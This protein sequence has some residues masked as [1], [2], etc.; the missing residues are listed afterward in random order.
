ME[1]ASSLPVE[2][3]KARGLA[4]AVSQL[5]NELE[6]ARDAIWR[7]EADLAAGVPVT[8]TGRD[9]EHLVLRLEAVLKGGAQA[10]GC[11]AAAVY[12][13]DEATTELKLRVGWGLPRHRLLALP[14][15]LRGAIADLEALVGHAVVLEDTERLPQ[16]RVPE[17][18]DA[19]VCVPICSPTE[20]LGTLWMFCDHPR[21]FSPDQTNLIEIIAGRIAAELQ[22]E[23][24]LRECVQTKRLDRQLLRAMEWQNDRLPSIQPL[25]GNWELAGWVG[26]NELLRAGFYDWCVPS[27]GSLAV[28]LGSAEG[29]ML[30][31]AMTAAA[32]HGALR[33]H[34]VHRHDAAQMLN[35][36]NET[37]WTGSA[38][39]QFA[40]LFYAL[41]QPQTGELEYASAGGLCGMRLTAAGAQCIDLAN[42]SLGAQPADIYTLSRCELQHGDALL[43]FS[44][45]ASQLADAAPSPTAL[46]ELAESCQEL[47][48]APTRELLEK[49]GRLIPAGENGS[50]RAGP[51]A[52]VVRRR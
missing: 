39:G 3:Y 36:V 33:A 6:S 42:P 30:E 16:W 45:P 13:L 40:S 32:L 11:Q 27:D 15:P 1:P 41:I 23:A 52:L 48:D 10:V 44:D 51:V 31:A 43:V 5:L 4:A 35:R 22:R 26:D 18:F 25:L 47:R 7:R 17:P 50:G 21:D 37:V 2:L 46:D 28:A 34:S 20:P 24:L 49:F 8:A 14:R 29:S 12:L 9:E 19:A 38:G